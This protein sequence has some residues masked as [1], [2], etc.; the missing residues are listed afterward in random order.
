MSQ[1]KNEPVLDV[2]VI[3][4]GHAGLSISYCLKQHNLKHIVF[5]RGRIGEVWRSQRWDSFAM[6]TANKNNVLP[7][8]TYL[9]NVPDGFGTANE[10][11]SSLEAYSNKN[12][13]PVQENTTV[14]SVNKP[15]GSSYFTVTVSENDTPTNYT[16][17][18]VIVASGCQNETRIPPFAKNISSEILQMHTRDYRNPSQLPEGAVLVAGSAQSG[19]QIAE[20]LI[21]AGKKVYLSTSR[22]ARIPRRYRGKD[23]VD[24]LMSMG[25]FNLKTEQVT[26]PAILD[27]KVP[28]LSGIGAFGH[29]I[30]LQALS[31]KGVVILGKMDHADDHNVYFAANAPEHVKFGDGFSMKC[32][33][34]VDDFIQK[35]QIV[36]ELP[37]E[38]QAD[39][40]DQNAS[41]ASTITSIPLKEHQ[42]SSIIWTTGF[43]G[44]F[45]Y[46]NLPVFNHDGTPKHKNGIS[47][48]TGLY[49][50]GLPWLR[51]RKSSMIFGINEDAAFI[52]DAINHH[53]HK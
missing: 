5:E 24:W 11:V 7:G 9:G 46:L 19:V 12:Q 30:S 53:H 26:D 3:G 37:E 44:D 4:G 31:K 34:M 29:T 22:V 33:G 10:F 27:M 17:K 32:K 35:N 14:I 6:N 38:D 23:I 49:F 42:I 16:S 18:Q 2:V 39:M 45:S 48:F 41:C 50:I 47:D 1:N 20:D 52:S 13:L 15:E 8:Q 43:N 21:D 28:L 40:P 51:M 25:F 36:A